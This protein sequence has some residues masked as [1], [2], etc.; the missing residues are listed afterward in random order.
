M[1][2]LGG[3]VRPTELSKAAGMNLLDLP[4]DKE[5]TLLAQWVE[6]SAAL[7]EAWGVGCLPLRILLEHT[8]AMPT[9][10]AIPERIALS[11]EHDPTEFRGTAGVLRDACAGYADE[12]WVVVANAGQVL[13]A[14]LVRLATCLASLEGEVAMAAHADGTPVTLMLLR[15]ACLRHLPRIG[16][17]DM[18]EQALPV[19]GQQY[20][21][22]V[23]SYGELVCRGV[24]TRESYITALQAVHRRSQ[25]G[26][27]GEAW[28]S[29]FE[30]CQAGA[31]LG[32]GVRL[33]NAVVLRGATVGREAVLV[34]SVAFPGAVVPA[35]TVVTDRLIS[36]AGIEKPEE[37]AA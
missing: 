6:E 30:I 21:I 31:T 8:S 34:R 28:R 23:A 24:R 11:L 17:V 12:E 15:C 19:I 36:A 1:I 27:L 16:Y 3:W 2:L 32:P 37:A 4:I 14:P 22:K 13:F 33:H 29:D 7:A 9:V 26:P 18:K 20:P 10:P 25:Q 5:R 35:G